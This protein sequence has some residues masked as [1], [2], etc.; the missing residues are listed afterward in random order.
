VKKNLE[1]AWGKTLQKESD[2]V[3]P[4]AVAGMFYPI[5]KGDL[6][7]SVNELL[8]RARENIVGEIPKKISVIISPHAGYL[9]SGFTAAHAYS[10]LH[11]NQFKTVVVVSPSHREYFDGLTV[12]SGRAYSTPLGEIEID[13]EI[14]SRF[15]ESA[16]D[17]AAKSQL[18]H[19]TEHAVEVQLPFLQ[20]TLLDFKLLPIVMGDQRPEYCRALGKILSGIVRDDDVLLVA[21]SDLSHYYEYNSANA[22]DAV[23]VDDILKLDSEKFMDDLENH[24]CEACGGGPVAASLH[25]ASELGLSRVSILHHCNSGDISGDKSAVVGYLSA[26]IS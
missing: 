24:R 1:F 2:Y 22:L 6:L 14:R 13:G 23:C 11:E 3:R 5:S 7:D 20:A 26:I 4:P 9:Y 8:G 21:S 16:G 12:F 18:G 25:A 15:M 10:L 19:R 17:L